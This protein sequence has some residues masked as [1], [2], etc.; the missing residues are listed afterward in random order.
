MSDL[1]RKR[2][3][4]YILL[5]GVLLLLLWL[6][7]KVGRII[8]ITRSLQARQLQAETMMAGGISQI[9]Q[10]QAEALAQGLRADVVA[11]KRETAIFMPF[12][13]VLRGVDRIGPLVDIAPQLLEMADAGTLAAAYLTEG[14][15][16]ALTIL[17]DPNR[18]GSPLPQMVQ[19]IDQ[20]RPQ[21]L[22]ATVQI[23]RVAAARQQIEN[24]PGLPWRVQEL[25]R[26]FDQL[27][28]LAQD[29]LRVLPILPAIMGQEGPRTYLI[30]AQNEDERRATGGFI[31]GVGLLQLHQGQ[32]VGLDFVDANNIDDWANKPYDF[33]PQPLYTFM[34][35]ELFLFRDA[36]F[37]PDFP[38]SAENMM[39]LYSYSQG[40]P[41]DGVIAVD[42]QFVAMLVGVLGP[43]SLQSYDLVVTGDNTIES[44][45]QAWEGPEGLG[46]G[47]WVYTRKDFIGLLAAALRQKLENN[48]GELDWPAFSQAMLAAVRQKHLQL[49]MRDPVVAVVLDGVNFDGRVENRVGQDFL[50][51][52]DS[53]MGYNKASALMNTQLDYDVTLNS[54]GTA[55]AVL[56][57]KQAHTGRRNNPPACEQGVGGYGLTGFDYEEMVHLCYWSYLRVYTPAGSQLVAASSHPAP[58]QAFSHNRPWNG[59]A[60]TSQDSSGLTMMENFALIPYGES[61][62]LLFQYQLPVTIRTTEADGS[63]RYLLQIMKQ[64]GTRPQ[65]LTVTV[66]LPAG[67]ALITAD[68]LPQQEENRLIFNLTLNQDITLFVHYR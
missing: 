50:L 34:G 21:L 4:F 56:S 26:Q 1:T 8:Q 32:I 60:A 43:I 62:D 42:Q 29:G 52:V 40:T 53:N 12:R 51:V 61:A 5:A 47:E 37:W 65:P 48:P 49:Y 38:T 58:A 22:Q 7:L 18:S 16:P 54:D 19:V 20:A 11:L 33:P 66:H 27:L 25:L 57:V 23:D 67:Q 30:V 45:R 10:A 55:A 36:N 39:N 44:M 59:Q 28:P 2:L 15:S 35:L 63:H 14:L 31:S 41:L 68:P 13:G 17:N 3:P 46:E 24:S 6:G 64:A 9:T